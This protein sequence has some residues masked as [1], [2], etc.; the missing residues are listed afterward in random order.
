VVDN[1]PAKTGPA[2]AKRPLP[3]MS[4]R[5][6][7]AQ[8]PML[9]QVGLMVGLAASVA[10]GFAVVLWSQQPDYRPLYGSLSGMDTKQVMDTLGAADIPYNVEPN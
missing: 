5:E 9:R 3:G 4:F 6:N 10:I 1:P 7:I 2:A 8:M